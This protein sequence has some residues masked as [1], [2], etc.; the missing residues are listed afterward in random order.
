MQEIAV[1]SGVGV[2]EDK[3]LALSLFKR[4]R[5]GQEI[6]QKHHEQVAEIIAYL[7]QAASTGQ[8]E[9]LDSLVS[10]LSVANG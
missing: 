4:C 7:R 10:D 9:N 8:N 3:E 2:V 6:P 1:A 5:V